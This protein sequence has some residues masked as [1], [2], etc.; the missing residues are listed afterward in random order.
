MA[1]LLFIVSF[2]VSA[3]IIKYILRIAVAKN[4][5]DNPEARKL[6]KEPVP[7][8]GGVVVAFGMI[9]AIVI[10]GTIFEMSHLYPLICIMMIMLYV[11][12]NGRYTGTFPLVATCP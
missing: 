10:G 8:L 6:Q 3:W 11:G 5:V 2:A 12:V 9:A 7:V 1:G 4:I